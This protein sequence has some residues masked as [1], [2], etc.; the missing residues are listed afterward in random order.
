M[1]RRRHLS[2]IVT[3]NHAPVRDEQCGFDHPFGAP[4]RRSAYS[5]AAFGADNLIPGPGTASCRRARADR[6]PVAR[7]LA[8]TGED[9]AFS[10]A[11]A[12]WSEI[13][14]APARTRAAAGDFGAADARYGLWHSDG[15]EAGAASGPAPLETLPSPSDSGA[16][17]ETALPDAAQTRA[18]PA[19]SAEGIDAAGPS[20]GAPTGASPGAPGDAV[21]FAADPGGP[22]S[23]LDLAGAGAAAA[24]GA[25][26]SQGGGAGGKAGGR[27]AERDGEA[28]KTATDDGD[29]DGARL[30]TD[31]QHALRTAQAS[32]IRQDQDIDLDG[33]V[34]EESDVLLGQR[35][36][37]DVGQD[38]DLAGPGR[39][40]LDSDGQQRAG[41]HQTQDLALG[42]IGP[43][44]VLDASDLQAAR[45]EQDAFLDGDDGGAQGFLLQLE[46]GDGV[47]LG[48]QSL[49]SLISDAGGGNALALELTQRLSLKEALEIREEGED[50]D[51]AFALAIRQEVDVEQLLSAELA[52][53]EADGTTVVRLRLSSATE[54][55]SDIEAQLD[56]EAAGGPLAVRV[57]QAVAV[58][59]ASGTSLAADPPDAPALPNPDPD[60]LA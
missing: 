56:L 45:V 39:L 6:R 42:D 59:Q 47:A 57:D 60:H 20:E 21:A 1:T 13:L 15:E 28:P 55:D 3:K 18:V 53:S 46:V 34:D 23:A 16:P 9:E 19:A 17:R 44:T 40:D 50:G 24:P 37:G 2:R 27:S 12:G 29:D 14:P 36:V 31:G 43:G 26:A 7:E 33:R 32:S 11:K 51:G 38:Q 4:I 49:V 30:G 41:I 35:Q 48:Q 8:M 25:A 22:A 52:V 5:R 10:T 54:L 58:A